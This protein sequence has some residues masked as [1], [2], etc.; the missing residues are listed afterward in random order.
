MVIS[1]ASCGKGQRAIEVTRDR[2]FDDNDS[3][4]RGSEDHGSDDRGSDDGGSD[5]RGF[6]DL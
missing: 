6:K 3:D 5:G 4:G 2:G 1:I